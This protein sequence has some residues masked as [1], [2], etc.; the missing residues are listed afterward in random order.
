[1]I[2]EKT[3]QQFQTSTVS[4]FVDSHSIAQHD[5]SVHALQSHDLKNAILLLK[6]SWDAS[7]KSII[8]KSWAKILNRD[9]DDFG[10]EDNISLAEL[11]QQTETDAYHDE[12]EETLQSFSKLTSDCVLSIGEIEDWNAD[13]FD[14]TDIFDSGDDDDDN[15]NDN[16]DSVAESVRIS[17]TD[18]IN[19]AN[20]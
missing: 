8:E 9:D 7:P 4:K 15:D 14:E 5:K 11:S 10:E 1:M 17:F 6:T 19:S 12:I 16:D 3:I 2:Q 20:M 18:A 13:M